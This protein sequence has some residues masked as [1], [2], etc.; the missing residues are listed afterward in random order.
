MHTALVTALA[1]IDTYD[2]VVLGSGD[3]NKML[4]WTE[5]RKQAPQGAALDLPVPGS[6]M[7]VPVHRKVSGEVS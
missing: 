6:P 4:D 2:A 7:L 1:P 3:T 5:S